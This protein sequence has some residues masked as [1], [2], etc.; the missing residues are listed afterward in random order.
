MH[1]S[2]SDFLRST[3]KFAQ[4]SSCFVHLLSINVQT[5]RKIFSNFV[6]FSESP[7]FH[8]I[9]FFFSFFQEFHGAY[10]SRTLLLQLQA[11]C[12]SQNQNVYLVQCPFCHIVPSKLKDFRRKICYAKK[13]RRIQLT[14]AAWPSLTRTARAENSSKR[15]CA[16]L[17][18]EFPNFDPKI[19]RVV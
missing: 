17:W 10:E 5:M 11:F 12:A 3:Q 15:T 4:S 19:I 1:N 2:S 6:C 9:V 13:H 8:I 14:P 16:S 18:T 7:N